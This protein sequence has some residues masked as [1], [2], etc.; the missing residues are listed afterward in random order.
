M[1]KLTELDDLT[2]RRN[3]LTKRR[4]DLLEKIANY[5][6]EIASIDK[7]F[8]VIRSQELELDLNGS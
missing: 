4:Y 7:L 6:D 1:I 3:A 2:F 5:A 8:E